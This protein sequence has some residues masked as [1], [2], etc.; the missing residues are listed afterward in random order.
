MQ[1]RD[2]SKFK[3]QDGADDED[4]SP[5]SLL[6]EQHYRKFEKLSNRVTI[7]TI[8]IPFLIGVIIF[9]GYKNVREMVTQSQDAGAK[10]LTSLTKTLE[11]S[12]SDLSVKQARLENILNEKLITAE[13]I[14]AMVKDGIRKSDSGILDSIRKIESSIAEIQSGK[15]NKKDLSGDI[16]AFDNKLTGLQ[17]QGTDNRAGLEKVSAEIKALDKKL[18]DELAKVSN[19]I[20]KATTNIAECQADIGILSSEKADRKIIETTLKNYEKRLQEINEQFLRN[21]K[22]IEKTKSAAEKN[23]PQTGD[24]KIQQTV[25][26]PQRP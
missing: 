10:E 3:F 15:M 5:E 13:R 1:Y 16:T 25:I 24:K 2:S 9:V 7:I 19:I 20:N 12:I 18:S 14:E 22:D 21:L 8:I 6:E 4:E 11:S 17:K 26:P 23:L